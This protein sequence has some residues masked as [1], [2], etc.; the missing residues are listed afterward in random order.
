MS[1]FHFVSRVRTTVFCGYVFSRFFGGYVRTFVQ[2]SASLFKGYVGTFL[3]VV[4][5]YCTLS[6]QPTNGTSRRSSWLFFFGEDTQCRSLYSFDG[7][8]FWDDTGASAW[9][10]GGARGG[11]VK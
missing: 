6:T 7:G 11:G 2:N 9:P 3:W 1:G 4:C 8:I 5:A 10:G